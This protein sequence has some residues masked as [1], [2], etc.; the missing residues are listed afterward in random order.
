[1]VEVGVAVKVGF[2]A[3][4]LGHSLASDHQVLEMSRHRRAEEVASVAEQR[5]QQ[6]SQRGPMSLQA[7][8]CFH[9]VPQSSVCCLG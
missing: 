6:R 1:M 9:F 4:G 3:I 5:V 7:R 8:S 2:D